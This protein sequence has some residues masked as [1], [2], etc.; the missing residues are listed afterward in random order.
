M[1]LGM[2]IGHSVA[3]AT[4]GVVFIG[5]AGVLGDELIRF[6][7]GYEMMVVSH[8]EE[9]GMII[10][11][12]DGGGEIGF[13]KE[14]LESLEGGRPTQRVGPSPGYNRLPPRAGNMERFKI[15]ED[16]H[17]RSPVLAH[18]AALRSGV[19]VGYSMHGEKMERFS[20]GPT[21][22]GVSDKVRTRMGGRPDEAPARETPSEAA[23]RQQRAKA[24]LPMVQPDIGEE[25]E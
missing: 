13:P 8:R 9:R 1:V 12:L 17:D 11:T 3:I 5:G 24:R 10:V 4:V 2:K 21:G 18:G 19:R 25:P 7:S 16:Y 23:K 22:E 15:P 14:A 20:E 6:K